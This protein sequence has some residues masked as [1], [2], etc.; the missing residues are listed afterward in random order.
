MVNPPLMV[1]LNMVSYNLIFIF[2]KPLL[3]TLTPYIQIQAPGT[4]IP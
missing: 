1:L 4:T 3:H 2:S